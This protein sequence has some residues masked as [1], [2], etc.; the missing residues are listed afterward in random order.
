MKVLSEKKFEAAWKGFWS[1]IEETGLDIN[2][3]EDELKEALRNA[4]GGL[5]EDTGIAYPGGLITHINVTLALADKIYNIIS[6]PPFNVLNIDK[7]SLIKVLLIMHLSKI[8]M[9]K[10]NDNTWEIEKR[11]LNFKFNDNLKG[12]LK[13]G[14]RSI[15]VCMDARIELTEEEFEAIRCIDRKSES[16]G[17]EMFDSTLSLVVRQINELAYAFERERNKIENKLI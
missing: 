17:S 3:K 10:P 7:N 16:T 13:F 4:A 12:R 8:E 14:E 11:G 15:L 5:S 1:R 6:E 9:Y 2:F